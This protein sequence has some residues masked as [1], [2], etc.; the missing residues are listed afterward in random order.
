[1][2]YGSLKDAFLGLQASQQ[3]QDLLQL[4]AGADPYPL[5]LDMASL[6]E[7][8]LGSQGVD[9]FS[10]SQYMDTLVSDE[11]FIPVAKRLP[12]GKDPI[13][14]ETIY[15]EFPTGGFG[16]YG[17]QVEVGQVYTRE[18]DLPRLQK[19]VEDRMPY[20]ERT[21]PGFGD[22]PFD[23]RNSMVSSNYRGSLPGSPNTIKFIQEKKFMQAGDE[24]LDNDEYRDAK[25]SEYK[26]GIRKRMERLSNALKGIQK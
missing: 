2:A 9:P 19:R 24:F 25:G 3:P 1:M 21:F 13:T 20:L 15:E 12:K 17:P 11:G 5:N 7:N 23:V 4:G 16:E 14:G 6:D 8:M 22:L 10:A 26:S 18:G